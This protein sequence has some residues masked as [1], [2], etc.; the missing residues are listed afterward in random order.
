MGAIKSYL[1][2]ECWSVV[3]RLWS[4][5]CS[6]FQAIGAKKMFRPNSVSCTQNITAKRY[7]SRSRMTLQIQG[8]PGGKACS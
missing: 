8:T 1:G 4:V 3:C 5:S 7:F 6:I 2:V